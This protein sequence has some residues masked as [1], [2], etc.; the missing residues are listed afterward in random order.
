M[1]SQ[2]GHTPPKNKWPL[3]WT[4]TPNTYIAGA[5]TPVIFF[6]VPNTIPSHPDFWGVPSA[7]IYDEKATTLAPRHAIYSAIRY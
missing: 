7:S 3:P 4:T 6:L 5:L 1:P 2:N